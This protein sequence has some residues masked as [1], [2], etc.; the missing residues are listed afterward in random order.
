ME[1]IKLSIITVSYNS[2]RTISETIVSV[3]NQTSSDFEYILIDGNSQDNTVSLIKSFETDFL[4]RGINYKWVS[5]KDDGIYDAMNKGIKLA[6]NSVIGFLNSDDYFHDN[7][8]VQD[9]LETWL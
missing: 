4:N 1:K 5:E 6:S 3:L 8:V 2:E 9:I 7:N